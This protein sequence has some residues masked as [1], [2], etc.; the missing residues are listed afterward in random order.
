VEVRLRS[1]STVLYDTVRESIG[2]YI[3]DNFASLETHAPVSGWEEIKFIADEVDSVCCAESA[4]PLPL[5]PLQAVTLHIHIYELPLE[6]QDQMSVMCAN[7]QEM[8]D[9]ALGSNGDDDF[10]DGQEGD[11]AAMRLE[12]PAR[13]LE[14]IWES[15]I[16]EDGVKTR[17]LNYIYS[18]VVFAEQNVNQA[19]IAW[20]RL[21]LLH[22]PPGTGKTSLCRALAQKISIRLSG[23]YQKTELVEI[24]SHSLFS[25]WFSESGK[26]VQSLFT[27][28]GQAADDPDTFVM[29]LIDEVESLAGSR[30]TGTSGNEPSDALRAVN[31]LL[32]ELDKLKHRRNVLV[33]TT[34]NITGSIDTYENQSIIDNAFLDRADIKQYIG[35][36][37]PEAIY[38][39]LR[40]CL[41]ELVKAEIVR[42]R[43]LLDYKETLMIRDGLEDPIRRV[44]IGCVAAKKKADGAERSVKCSIKLLEIAERATGMSGRTLRRLPL[45]AHARTA[46]MKSGSK[47]L[48]METYLNGM[49]MAV[50]DDKL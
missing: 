15:L 1:G 44:R 26:L 47:M 35:L 18:S 34:S 8:S 49:L 30:S 5:V 24:N 11:V 17:L 38:W 37:P 42:P 7:P 3:T 28:I 45:L 32:T 40:T 36:P 48:T 19:L 20:H 39:I 14:G 22:G 9:G 46:V 10:E 43:T 16:Y 21:L 13:R 2:R 12:L 6:G 33:L 41:C 31:A 4:H 29:V 23:M 27:K 50:E 25:K